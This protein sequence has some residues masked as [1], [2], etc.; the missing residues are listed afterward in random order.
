MSKQQLQTLQIACCAPAA[1]EA[2]ADRVLFSLAGC[3]WIGSDGAEGGGGAGGTELRGGGG[4][5][6]RERA[7]RPHST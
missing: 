4:G 1:L 3:R 5:E 6:G 2:A 7:G